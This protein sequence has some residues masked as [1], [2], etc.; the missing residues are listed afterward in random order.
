MLMP[1][2]IITALVGLVVSALMT[3]AALVYAR[4]SGLLDQPGRRRSHTLPTPRGG[5]V[6][7]VAA[8]L[9]VGVPAW[10]LV[11]AGTDRLRILGLAIAVCVVAVIGW[12]DDHKPMA[13][14]PRILV[15]VAAAS[16]TG[17][18]VIAPWAAHN[19]TWWWLVVPL[20]PV[21]AGFINAH[22]FM[23]GIDG[24]LGGQGL[25]VT[26]V[27]GL[28]AMWVHASGIA[29]LAFATA[30]GCVGFLLF[31]APPARVFMGDVGSGALG[32]AIAGI[33]ALVV[34]CRPTL[35]WACA[36][37][38]SSFL[39]DSGLTLARRV[40]AG[41][42]WYAPH[43]QH[44]YQWLVRLNWSHAR[45]DVVYMTWNL[46]VVAPLTWAA[47]R[48]PA[49][50]VWCLGAAYLMAAGVWCA[51]KRACLAS[52]RAGDVHESA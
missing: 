21:F 18:V 22:N 48:W 2:L 8:V 41:Q 46:A 4:R 31:N 39:V 3:A 49:H 50:G 15:H 26:L 43:R 30:A 47:A 12:R 19:S 5:G 7:I 20:V 42:R 25:F 29:A 40:V 1:G 35:F 37:V 6:G 45:T 14:L 51:G 52:A 32:L 27:F 44:L 28:L 11:D 13:V 10:W 16:L 24:I 38:P 17:I 9:L 33:G 34:A 23:D 36:I